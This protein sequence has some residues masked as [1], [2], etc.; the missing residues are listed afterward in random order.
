MQ[1]I[2]DTSHHSHKFNF[3]LETDN[4]DGVIYEIPEQLCARCQ[5]PLDNGTD[6]LGLTSQGKVVTEG[7]N[8]AGTSQSEPTQ[9]GAINSQLDDNESGPLT[10][11]GSIGL[12]GNKPGINGNH[13]D[14]IIEP[15]S[16][17]PSTPPQ[18]SVTQE[19][20]LETTLSHP[21]SPDSRLNNASSPEARD[22]AQELKDLADVL[23]SNLEKS[24]M[25]SQFMTFARSVASGSA[26]DLTNSSFLAFQY[27]QGVCQ[28][29]DGL[30]GMDS[31]ES[32]E[33]FEGI[34]GSSGLIDPDMFLQTTG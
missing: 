5:Q 27:V 33:S 2:L 28:D 31:L 8:K 3:V 21:V 29:D 32:M 10:T 18:Q 9:I 15:D 17:K 4:V 16:T 26:P 20:D 1:N 7:T 30:E 12:P 25:L 34:E 24:S 13:G 6:D 14:S 11:D 19:V 22:C 23:V